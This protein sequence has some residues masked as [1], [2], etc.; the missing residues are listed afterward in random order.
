MADTKLNSFECRTH[1]AHKPYHVST[2][3]K[4]KK[5]KKNGKT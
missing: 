3:K 2:P 4:R 5:K 1:K